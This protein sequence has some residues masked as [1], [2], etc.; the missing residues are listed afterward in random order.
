MTTAPTS[1][2]TSSTT[3]DRTTAATAFVLVHGAWGGAHTWRK[4]R[5]LLWAAG[6]EVFT[7]SLTGIGER[8]HLTGPQITL[9]THIDDV[10]GTIEYEGLDDIV[11]L[12]FS[13]GGMVVTGALDRVADRVRELVYLDAFV[14]VDGQSA[15]DVV[16]RP[17]AGSV[18]T[19]WAVEGLPRVFEDTAEGEFQL[20]HRSLQPIRTL[21]EPVRLSRP[22]EDHPFGLTY[23]KALGDTRDPNAPDMFYAAADRVRDNPRW[24]YFESTSNHMI[25]QN[26][27]QELVDILLQLT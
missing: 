22:L 1:S 5:P 10:V 3:S 24:R 23:I 21:D 14:P 12:G 2:T 25:P 6:H 17:F 19:P 20:A 4:V 9:R 11:L 26:R 27:P 8:E 7:P 15:F 18:H 16:G 13:Y